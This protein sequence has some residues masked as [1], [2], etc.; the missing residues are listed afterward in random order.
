[1]PKTPQTP[2]SFSYHPEGHVK[3]FH[4]PRYKKELKALTKPIAQPAAKPPT[5][6]ISAPP[7]SPPVTFDLPFHPETKQVLQYPNVKRAKTM[8]T[9][10]ATS[11][12]CTWSR[13]TKR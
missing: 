4:D 8:I 6:T 1:M 7:F 13:A 5:T 2:S 3:Y 9:T 11:A 10:L 12:S